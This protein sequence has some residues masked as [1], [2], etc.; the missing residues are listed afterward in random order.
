MDEVFD[1]V[2]R[3]L[4]RSNSIQNPVSRRRLRRFKSIIPIMARVPIIRL[5]HEETS[6]HCDLSFKSLGSVINSNLMRFYTLYDPRVHPLMTFIRYWGRMHSLL[7]S[8]K[9]KPYALMLM[10]VVYLNQELILPNLIYLQQLEMTKN[11]TNLMMVNGWNFA[12][13]NDVDIVRKAASDFVKRPPDY[14][15]REVSY[16]DILQLATG[17]FKKFGAFDFE[18]FVIC[19]LMGSQVDKVVFTD[20]DTF[21]SMEF[22]ASFSKLQKLRHSTSMCVQD[23]FILDFNVTSNVTIKIVK[24][25]TSLC[26]ETST[27]LDKILLQA[28]EQE[29]GINLFSEV[30]LNTK[31]L[32]V[33]KISPALPLKTQDPIIGNIVDTLTLKGVDKV[34]IEKPVSVSVSKIENIVQQPNNKENEAITPAQQADASGNSE[35][36]MDVSLSEYNNFEDA[37]DALSH[38]VV[39]TDVADKNIA[40]PDHELF[41]HPFIPEIFTY[42]LGL[43]VSLEF[44]QLFK[45]VLS[46]LDSR[47]EVENRMKITWVAFADDFFRNIFDKG[48]GLKIIT[49]NKL[50][51]RRP[52][53][54][55]LEEMRDRRELDDCLPYTIDVSLDGN[56]KR[57][58]IQT[59][60]PNSS[61]CK[62]R[63]HSPG[64]PQMHQELVKRNPFNINRR[65]NDIVESMQS[66]DFS[67]DVTDGHNFAPSR[68]SD[69]ATR[70]T[71]DAEAITQT[72]GP[73]SN[74][75]NANNG[76]EPTP[77]DS[78]FI[79][80][81]TRDAYTKLQSGFRKPFS[82]ALEIGGEADAFIERKH[83]S[84]K[85][86]LFTQKSDV[87]YVNPINME[88]RATMTFGVNGARAGRRRMGVNFHCNI[89]VDTLEPFVVVHLNEVLDSPAKFPVVHIIRDT[90]FSQM[91]HQ[92]AMYRLKKMLSKPRTN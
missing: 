40:P 42:S 37:A 54:L 39:E 83:R 82:M 61:F 53:N 3:Q 44:E 71:S 35:F 58:K 92:Y 57:Y 84:F 12:F 27:I 56:K 21:A 64:D 41:N 28:N 91:F 10:I 90:G 66:Q 6:L 43:S 89:S 59:I 55:N 85:R 18:S 30:F 8:N 72:A 2:L 52:L 26:R 77:Q 15:E 46:S 33:K 68:N 76:I 87:L 14:F 17:F 50:P 70:S 36:A 19:P 62:K 23:P 73:I 5:I 69:L 31:G 29:N 86:S 80:P 16:K 47:V 25:F 22:P 88:E 63:D 20:P 13:M 49:Q 78:L 81:L 38:D 75:I 4:R 48:F 65:G 1:R 11:N 34:E 51:Y 9:I 74:S 67:M 7:G 60:L 32:I 24:T 79:Y 45:T